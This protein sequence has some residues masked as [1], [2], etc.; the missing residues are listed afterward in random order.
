[1][2]ILL[3]AVLSVWKGGFNPRNA[4]NVIS[5]EITACLARRLTMYEARSWL[6][7]WLAGCAAAQGWGISTSP[8]KPAQQRLHLN[9]GVIETWN[10]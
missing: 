5:S 6:A 10:T 2:L 4:I 7:G 1:M 8:E 9:T 3:L